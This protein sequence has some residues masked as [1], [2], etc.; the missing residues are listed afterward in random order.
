MEYPYL[1]IASES[2]EDVRFEDLQNSMPVELNQILMPPPLEGR[3]SSA[4]FPFIP[5]AVLKRGLP[6]TVN[7]ITVPSPQ[8]NGSSPRLSAPT[9]NSTP[10][11]PSAFTSDPSPAQFQLIPEMPVHA[12]RRVPN[13]PVADP[14][15]D[16][17]LF[18]LSLPADITM[19]TGYGQSHNLMDHDSI[20]YPILGSHIFDYAYQGRHTYGNVDDDGGHVAELSPAPNRCPD[21]G[22]TF[23][24]GKHQFQRNLRRHRIH[25]CQVGATE[26]YPCRFGGCEAS[27]TRTDGR[28]YH[29]KTQHR[30][31]ITGNPAST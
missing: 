7:H 15:L 16:I 10:S 26:K 1:A 8:P 9:Y 25:H 22:V 5:E 21:C 12:I 20:A 11:A 4:S 28:K 18:D 29:E 24:G 14:L 23:R 2:T 13:H 30:L 19:P 27:F 17:T 3:Q 31:Y 6:S